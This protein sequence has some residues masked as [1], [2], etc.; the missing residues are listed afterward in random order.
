M[1]RDV[2]PMEAGPWA[3]AGHKSAGNGS[4]EMLWPL[5]CEWTVSNWRFYSGDKHRFRQSGIHHSRRPNARSCVKRRRQRRRRRRQSIGAPRAPGACPRFS[6]RS[7]FA[8]WIVNRASPRHTVFMRLVYWFP[9]RFC[10]LFRFCSLFSLFCSSVLL[11][12]SS[13]CFINRC[14]TTRVLLCLHNL[15]TSRKEIAYK[16]DKP[17]IQLKCNVAIREDWASFTLK[18][19]WTV[20]YRR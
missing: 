18:T 17:I 14:I 3:S 16:N 7:H 8:I 19:D 9:R 12:A 6:S 5:S 15:F 1:M 13:V 2:F 20:P 4:F 10:F 11:I